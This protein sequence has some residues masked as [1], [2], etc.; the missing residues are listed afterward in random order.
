MDIF[1]VGRQGRGAPPSQVKWIKPKDRYMEKKQYV[2]KHGDPST[3]G[4]GHKVEDGPPG[5]LLVNMGNDGI[6]ERE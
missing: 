3:N 2:G 4:L 6:W 1:Q 5:V